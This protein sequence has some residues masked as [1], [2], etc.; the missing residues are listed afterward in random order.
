MTKSWESDI[1]ELKTTINAEYNW[2]VGACMERFFRELKNRK[3]TGVQ[4]AACKKVYVPPR[5]ICEYCFAET[6][7]WV[8]VGPSGT[9][10]SYT[11]GNVSV[12]TDVGGLKNQD[13]PAIIALI[14]LD[15]ADS[16][17]VHRIKE[18]DIA[19]LKVDMRVEVVWADETAGK[20]ADI[21]Y[22]KPVK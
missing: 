17:I 8:E 2:S 22:F 5:M 19:D 7:D 10:R 16:C 12:D 1:K 4:C 21:N 3:L 9:I 18:I 13:E 20:L 14:Q 15:K 6:K 11:Y